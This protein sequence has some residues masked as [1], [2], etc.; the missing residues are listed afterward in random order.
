MLHMLNINAPFVHI[1]KGVNPGKI[2]FLK[3]LKNRG[4]IVFDLLEEGGVYSD[5]MSVLLPYHE[6]VLPCVD[7]VLLWGEAQKQIIME[8]RKNIRDGQLMVTGYPSFDLLQNDKLDYYEKLS[9]QNKEIG[10]G[11]I[12]INTNFACFN[13]QIGFEESKRVNK[14]ADYLYVEEQRVKYQEQCEYEKKVYNYFIEMVQSLAKQLKDIRIVVRPHPAENFSNY[15]KHFEEISNVRVIRQGSVREWI[16][17]AKAV[18]HHDCTTGIESFL[19]G[20]PTI[21]YVPILEK[22]RT[23]SLPIDASEKVSTLNSLIQMMDALIEDNVFSYSEPYGDKVQRM[24]PV[25]ANISFKAA[26]RIVACVE[27]IVKDKY[28]KRDGY[29]QTI[30]L[31]LHWLMLRSRIAKTLKIFFKEKTNDNIS[32]YQ[33]NK[34]QGISRNDICRRLMILRELDQAMPDV[35]VKKIFENTYLLQRQ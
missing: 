22:K 14:N 21:S 16:I 15:E 8:N 28:K 17:N 20:I 6:D 4:G 1:D 11:Y 10:K 30:N 3:K 5:M 7:A 12:L 31:R 19:M 29:R 33:R 2:E 26:E 34:F 13:G 23:C 9:R 27:E 35:N 18:I 25:I 32:Q 24:S